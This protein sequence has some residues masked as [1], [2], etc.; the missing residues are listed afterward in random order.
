MYKEI[1]NFLLQEE[2]IPLILFQVN[3]RH[4]TLLNMIN[5]LNPIFYINELIFEYLFITHQLLYQ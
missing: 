3:N 2:E 5:L 1:I 4:R